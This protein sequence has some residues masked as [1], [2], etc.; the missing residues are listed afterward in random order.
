M[1]KYGT[2][3]NIVKCAYSAWESGISL[4]L[5]RVVKLKQL[6]CRGNNNP[7]NMTVLD[8]KMA[9][10]TSFGDSLNCSVVGEIVGYPLLRLRGR[11]FGSTLRGR[12]LYREI[13]R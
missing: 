13:N 10:Q 5:G 2:F 11:C 4:F 7:L 9:P 12:G 3:D 8:D 6:S 1:V